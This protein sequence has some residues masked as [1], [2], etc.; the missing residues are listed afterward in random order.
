[1]RCIL[2]QVQDGIQFS[3]Y[4]IEASGQQQDILM[5]ETMAN[6]YRFENTMGILYG[7]SI[8]RQP[9]ADMYHHIMEM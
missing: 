3:I 2:C 8:A 4:R 1:M 7:N 5:H 9:T 6:D